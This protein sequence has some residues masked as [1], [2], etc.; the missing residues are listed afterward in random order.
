MIEAFVPIAIGGLVFVGCAKLLGV[1]EI[2]K[3][4]KIFAKKFGGVK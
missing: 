1:T 4:Y 3:V 2:E